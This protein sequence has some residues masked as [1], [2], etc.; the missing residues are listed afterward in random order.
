MRSLAFS[1][2]GK[3]LAATGREGHLTIWDLKTGKASEPFATDGLADG[4]LAFSPDGRTIATRGGD[5]CASLL[6][7]DRR[8]RTAW[9]LPKGTSVPSRPS[10]SFDQGKGLIS[11]SDDH[12][13][14][15]WDLSRDPAGRAGSEP[16]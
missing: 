5:C 11:G 14:R 1:P 9:R 13:V 15:I 12:T 10:F 7:P 16:S 3:H 6:G 4:P 2:D 8:S